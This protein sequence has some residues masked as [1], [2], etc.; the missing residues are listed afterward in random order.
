MDARL[1]T[2][3]Q[4]M[5]LWA[6]EQFL[7]GISGDSYTDDGHAPPGRMFGL[8]LTAF[9][10]PELLAFHPSVRI[11]VPPWVTSSVLSLRRQSVRPV[12]SQSVFIET[13]SYH[14]GSIT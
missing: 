12:G 5:S 8:F 9:P 6:F 4:G 14:C 2:R 7:L 11:T 13:W 10:A 3:F 1:P